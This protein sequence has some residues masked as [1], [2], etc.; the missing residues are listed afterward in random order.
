[1]KLFQILFKYIIL[2]F[3]GGIVYYG[4]EILWRGFSHPTMLAAGAICFIAIGLLN[5]N[6][7]E[8]NMSFTSQ[9]FLSGVVITAIEFIFGLIFNIGLGW[10]IWD[11]SNQF[12]NFMGQICIAYFGLW[13]FLSILAILL[14][15]WTD[16]L[17]SKILKLD[18]VRPR[19]RVI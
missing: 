15:D 9:M 17:L 5:D 12:M 3:V 11:Y 14:Y 16:Y 2:T 10:A 19:Y 4:I 13:Q 8:W 18:A 1:M 7:F 6:M